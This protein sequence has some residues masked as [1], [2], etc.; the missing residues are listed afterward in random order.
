M[1]LDSW[2]EHLRKIKKLVLTKSFFLKK[3]EK[4][5][6]NKKKQKTI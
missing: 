1:M 2:A 5:E 3:K 6:G 4:G